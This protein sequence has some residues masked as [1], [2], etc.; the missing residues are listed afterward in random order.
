MFSNLKEKLVD[1]WW[2]KDF[3]LIW[4]LIFYSDFTTVKW[5][6]VI[7]I[8]EMFCAIAPSALKMRIYRFE[9]SGERK[10]NHLLGFLQWS[11]VIQACA[12][13][14]AVMLVQCHLY[15]IYV[16]KCHYSPCMSTDEYLVGFILFLVDICAAFCL[17]EQRSIL[18]SCE[19]SISENLPMLSINLI[20]CS[21]NPFANM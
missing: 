11:C 14:W 1:S 16:T 8:K 7:S 10:Q 12:V 5:F 9:V 18:Q 21:C 15:F 13:W 4:P 17:W 3:L 2:P 6:L 19:G 20:K